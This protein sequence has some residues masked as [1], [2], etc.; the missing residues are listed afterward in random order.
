MS[1]LST[2]RSRILGIA[3]LAVA[4]GGCA[5]DRISRTSGPAATLIDELTYR[6]GRL[7]WRGLS[8][9]GTRSEI[10]ARLGHPLALREAEA[11]V[12][13]EHFADVRMGGRVVT[14]QFSGAG[15]DAVLDSLFI[16]TSG[17]GAVDSLAADLKRRFPQAEYR[18]SRHRPEL[19]EPENPT[20]LYVMGPESDLAVLVKPVG[21]YLASLACLD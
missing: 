16:P 2:S 9:G 3:L 21:I 19:G 7:G 8:I 6:D 17:T 14:L 20:P 4:L 15:T 10:E 12:C 11:P 1:G 5:A 18:P 13:G